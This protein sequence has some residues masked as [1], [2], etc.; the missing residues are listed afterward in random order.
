MTRA[1]FVLAALLLAGCPDDVGQSAAVSVQRGLLAPTDLAGSADG[2]SRMMLTWADHATSETGYRL[3]ANLG[4]FDSPTVAGVEFLAPNTTSH[5]YPTTPNAT[6][7]FR[8]VAITASLESDPSNV[9]VATA[10]PAQPTGV[11]ANPLSSSSGLWVSWGDVAGESGYV[12]ERSA[13]GGMFWIEVGTAPADAPGFLSPGLSPDTEY[14]HRVIAVNS[15][16][17]STPSLPAQAQTTTDRVTFEFLPTSANNG[18]FTALFA[19]DPG[20]LHVAHVDA[21]STGVMVTS[22]FGTL[23]PYV[24]VTADGGPTGFEDVGGDG[25]GLTVEGAMGSPAALRKAHVVAHDRTTDVLRYAT[26]A[27][28]AWARATVDV[29]GGARPK[30]VRDHA[31][32]ALHVAYQG[33]QPGGPTLMRVARKLQGQAWT[34]RDFF[35]S[36][37]DSTAVHSMALDPSGR[38][39]V[40]LVTA[41]GMLVHAYEQSL[42]GTGSQQLLYP[43]THGV[44]DYTALAIEADGTVHAIYRGSLSKSLHHLSL[45]PGATEWLSF[46][47]D[48]APGEDL[49][50]FCSASLDEVSGRLHVAYYDATRRDLKCATKAPGYGWVRRIIDVTGDVGSHASIASVWGTTLYF[51]Y[52]DETQKRLKIAVKEF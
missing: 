1:A 47:V 38:L 50:S 42:G 3:E 45:A 41:T 32:G 15:G 29:N 27:S 48:E 18:M 46:S 22:R 30:I 5:V 51:A 23:S 35:S 26:D 9:L 43:P 16:G 17:R 13:D 7:Y 36:P 20:I 10:P 37:I 40:L 6:Y 52:R 12:I 2:G 21:E 4:P 44:P 25:I 19:R 49:G 14:A 33:R 39:H 8:V 11:V 34:A 24:T 28:G 31:S